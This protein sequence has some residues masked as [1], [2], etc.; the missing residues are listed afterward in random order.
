[1][2]A[3]DIITADR[4]PQILGPRQGAHTLKPS[5]HPQQRKPVLKRILRDILTQGNI[6]TLHIGE[7]SSERLA[8]DELRFAAEGG[9][10]FSQ[11]RLHG[12]REVRERIRRR[13]RVVVRRSHEGSHRDERVE[14]E[15]VFVRDAVG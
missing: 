9:V 15:M 14:G 4:L 6:L 2:A 1:M 3:A 7:E 5:P 11:V 13:R 8:R 10:D 12:V